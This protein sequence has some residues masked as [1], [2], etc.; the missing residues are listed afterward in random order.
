MMMLLPLLVRH[1]GRLGLDL[2]RLLLGQV[3]EARQRHRLP[4]LQLD[5]AADWQEYRATVTPKQSASDVFNSFRLTV[6]GGEG[7]VYFAMFSLFPPTF[8]DRPNGMR[9]DI[10]Q[11][12]AEVEPSIWRFPGGNNLEGQTP[13]TR[14]K[15][16]ETIGP[17]VDRPGRMG[18]WTYQNTDGLGLIEYLE[19][20]EGSSPSS[21]LVAA[22]EIY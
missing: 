7:S 20:L 11:T 9:I 4:R 22:G 3:R 12:I 15:W 1:Q 13:G 5:I 2:Q 8:K 21:L 10:A 16:N 6:T 18:D 14:W 17:L 19:W